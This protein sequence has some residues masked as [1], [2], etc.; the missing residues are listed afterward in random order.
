MLLLRELFNEPKRKDEGSLLEAKQAIVQFCRKIGNPAS[1][2]GKNNGDP[3]LI[4]Q[5]RWAM[6]LIDAL[7]ELEQSIYASE[8]YRHRIKLSAV[9]HMNEEER[10]NYRTYLYFYKNAFIRVFSLL[11][12]LGYFMNEYLG[13]HTERV[14][15]RFSYFTVLREM[16][17]KKYEPELS[18]ELDRLKEKYEIALKRLREQRN[19]EIHS[20]NYEL[21][22]DSISGR[23]K[24]DPLRRV[25]DLERNYFDILQALEM[26]TS[27]LTTVFSYCA[28]KSVMDQRRN[29]RS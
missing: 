14:K 24:F 21:L 7:E 9:E 3:K 4:E 19:F 8:K 25:E 23:G 26:A 11:D 13:V 2:P 27:S 12:K 6:G 29:R 28:R 1:S 22:N 10:V 20:I 17:E 15:P 18:A 16:R 5:E